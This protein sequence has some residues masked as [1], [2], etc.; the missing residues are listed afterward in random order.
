MSEHPLHSLILAADY[1]VADVEGM[2]AQLQ[3]RRPQLA[4][5]AAHHVVVYSSLWEPGRVL[6][7]VGI[8][9]PQSVSEVMRSPA[10]FE[11]FD[12]SGVEDIPAVFAG[13]VVEKIDLA[14]SSAGENGV[15]SVIVGVVTAVHDVPALMDKVHDAVGR[16]R[17]A[18]VCKVWVYQ[19]FDDGHEVLILQQ[20]ENESA[21]RRWIDHPDAAAEWMSA[22]GFGVYP[23]VFVGTLAHMSS[24]D[25]SGEESN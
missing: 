4:D 15:A 24:L 18:G 2:W 5:I 22:A 13:E 10:I 8:H 3:A 25:S 9:H 7:T 6:V 17:D 21:A 19:A 12:A 1:R 11:F 14:E 16:F 20:I 23:T